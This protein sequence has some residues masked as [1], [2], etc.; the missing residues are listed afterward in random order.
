MQ[1]KFVFA[2]G[3]SAKGS[4]QNKLNHHYFNL[5][6]SC[7]DGGMSGRSITAKRQLSLFCF[8][9]VVFLLLFFSEE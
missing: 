8:V 4:F 6:I 5:F 3:V 2:K 1:E 7:T 9:V